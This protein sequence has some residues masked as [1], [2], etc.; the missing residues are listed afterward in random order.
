MEERR[1]EL[2][3][4]ESTLVLYARPNKTGRIRGILIAADMIA[5]KSRF[6]LG[7]RP[8]VGRERLT[9]LLR[10]PRVAESIIGQ[11]GAGE[12]M[13]IRQSSSDQEVQTANR[14]GRREAVAC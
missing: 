11:A 7:T 14:W 10:Q 1:K 12:P 2:R 3:E 13:V 4:M 8:K 9:S 6:P 5:V